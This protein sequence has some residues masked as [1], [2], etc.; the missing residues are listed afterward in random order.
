MSSSAER[1]DTKSVFLSAQI[2][3]SFG[4]AH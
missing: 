1:R 2:R 3:T 4:A